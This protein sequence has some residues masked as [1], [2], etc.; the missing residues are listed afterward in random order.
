MEGLIWLLTNSN[1]TNIDNYISLYLACFQ[2]EFGKNSI[3]EK[4]VMEI[5]E[6]QSFNDSMRISSSA[7]SYIL[8]ELS[9]QTNCFHLS[10]LLKWLF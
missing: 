1:T 2:E 5:I 3:S 8:S 10:H 6:G 9:L 7:D 4:S